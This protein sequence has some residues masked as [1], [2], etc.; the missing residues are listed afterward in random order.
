MY[1]IGNKHFFHEISVHEF[2]F[3][4]VITSKNTI[5]IPFWDTFRPMCHACYHHHTFFKY[6][7]IPLL[8][9]QIIS[10][11]KIFPVF[12]AGVIYQSLIIIRL[13]K[14]IDLHDDRFFNSTCAWLEIFIFCIRCQIDMMIKDFFLS[15]WN[16]KTT[17]S[18]RSRRFLQLFW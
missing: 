7:N 11:Q 3:T 4:K 10:G 5:I 17:L 8:K 9:T 15:S 18:L 16:H 13:I 2:S 12:K 14:D 6:C 1:E